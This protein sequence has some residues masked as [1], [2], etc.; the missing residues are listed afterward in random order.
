ML[1]NAGEM[2]VEEGDYWDMRKGKDRNLS[3]KAPHHDWKKNL[4]PCD[5]K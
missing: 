5:T 2:G 3:E 1:T 4:A